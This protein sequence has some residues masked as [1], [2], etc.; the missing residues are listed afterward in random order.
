VVTIRSIHFSFD[1][2]KATAAAGV[3]LKKCP[4]RRM[5]YIRLLK[6]LYIADRE[7]LR[8]RG[9]PIVGDRYISMKKGAAR[10]RPEPLRMLPGQTFFDATRQVEDHRCVV[11]SDPSR[12]PDNDV[13]FVKITTLRPWKD[14]TCIITPR[15]YPSLVGDSCIFTPT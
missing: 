11:V 12:F 2:Q 13:I 3:L 7:S 15:E 1:E 9:R 10:S 8:N 5:K 14:Q 6:L 4:G